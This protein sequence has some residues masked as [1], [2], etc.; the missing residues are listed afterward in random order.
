M[1]ATKHE[2]AIMHKLDLRQIS[3]KS[4]MKMSMKTITI[5]SVLVIHLMIQAPQVQRLRGDTHYS[6]T[7]SALLLSSGYTS[8]REIASVSRRRDDER[9]AILA[10]LRPDGPSEFAR[11][12]VPARIRRSPARSEDRRRDPGGEEDGTPDT[13]TTQGDAGGRRRAAAAARWW[14]CA[15]VW[16]RARESSGLRSCVFACVPGVSYILARMP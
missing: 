1:Q 3:S 8:S 9:G 11:I 7:T 6:L 12:R 10:G 16:A 15:R 13:G 5:R 2:H 4:L 14:W